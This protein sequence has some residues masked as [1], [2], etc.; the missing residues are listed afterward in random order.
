MASDFDYL[1][2]KNRKHDPAVFYHLPFRIVRFQ[3]TDDTFE[4]VVTNLNALEFPPKEL[5]RLYNMGWGIETAFRELKYTIGLL[6]FHAKRWSKYTR[7]S[8]LGLSCTTL[9]NWLPCP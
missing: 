5:K 6:H 2:K 9:L 1:S 8:L 7:R 3:I 4:T